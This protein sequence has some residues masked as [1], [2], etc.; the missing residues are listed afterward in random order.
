[1]IVYPKKFPF[2]IA[3]VSPIFDS[4]IWLCSTRKQTYFFLFSY[5]C[6]CVKH[7]SF[8]RLFSR[9]FSHRSVI[10]AN[11]IGASGLFA[12]FTHID[13]EFHLKSHSFKYTLHLHED[14]IP[15]NAQV[16]F[17]QFSIDFQNT[18]LFHLVNKAKI[19]CHFANKLA[20]FWETW[21]TKL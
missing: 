7:R 3:C 9:L 13:M 2:W 10:A 11:K 18:I 6:L 14:W 5:V 20:L 8:S 21:A 17:R 1:M 12:F 19:C 4:L 16:Y 15:S